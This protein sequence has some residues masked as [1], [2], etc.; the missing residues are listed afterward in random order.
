MPLTASSASPRSLRLPVLSLVAVGMIFGLTYGL[1]TP[2]LT[3][4]LA[5]KGYG[6]HVIAALAMMHG[7]GVLGIAPFLPRLSAWVGQKRLLLCALASTAVILVLFPLVP[8]VWVWFPLR[9]VLGMA[10]ETM[11]IMSESWLN[12]ST[13]DSNRTRTM[14]LYSAMLSSGFAIGPVVLTLV[15]R[16]GLAPFAISTLLVLVVFG[17]VSMPWM[18]APKA[19]RP[20][21]R[22][23][24]RYIALA[25]VAIS[26]TLL[27]AMLEATSSAFLPLYALHSGWTERQAMLL[28]SVMLLGAIVLQTPLGWLA[29]RLKNPRAMLIGLGLASTLGALL[30]PAAIGNTAVAYPLL[31]VWDGLF[32]AL[33]TVAMSVV[34]SRFSGG[35]LV[36]VYAATSVAWGLGSFVG[37]GMAGTALELSPAS[38]LPCFVA[39]A[40]GLFTLLPVFLKKR[41]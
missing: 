9:L 33:Y 18:R 14:G 26:V 15:G 2:L 25:P 36:S 3:F 40:C 7:V 24:L 13:D 8:S 21:H 20:A 34:G 11:L 28:L 12:Q 39:L 17:M 27:M 37:P 35:D 19:E 22:G 6:A 32:A 5:D 30:W 4:A 29:D 31:F 41:A 10:T 1:S 16:H 23:L 38:G